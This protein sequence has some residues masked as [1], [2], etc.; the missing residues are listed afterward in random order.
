MQLGIWLAIAAASTGA[1]CLA[2]KLG[3]LPAAN[4]FHILGTGLLFL[5]SNQSLGA[6]VE[7]P[8]VLLRNAVMN[9]GGPLIQATILE[10]VPTH[11]QGKWS[12]VASLR[13]M[14]WS[15]SA[16]IGGMLSDSHDYRYAFFI[17]ACVHTGAG[18]LLLVVNLLV[19]AH[20]RGGA[21]NCGASA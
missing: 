7:V 9:S 2:R 4:V 3:R 19:Y 17:T 21:A 10:L 14:T 12:S 5:I 11:H 1:P 13:R 20:E 6:R 16:F 18:V 15:G 8:L